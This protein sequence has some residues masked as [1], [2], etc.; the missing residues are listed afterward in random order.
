MLISFPKSNV[1][2]ALI[3]LSIAMNAYSQRLGLPGI[4]NFSRNQ[5]NAGTQNWAISQAENGLLYFANNKGLLEFNGAEWLKYSDIGLVYRSV[6]N[7]GNRI[8]VGGFNFFGYYESNQAG[9]LKYHSLTEML[10]AGERDFD[11]IWKIHKTS[12]G[13]VFQSFRGV[14]IYSENKI[15]IV[16]PRSQFHFSYYV[17]GI[18]WIFDQEAGLM[19][20]REGKVR[21]IP[22]GDR[23]SHIEIWTILPYNDDK[24]LVGT[25]KNGLY[26]Y[27]GQTVAKWETPVSGYLERYQLFAGVK[28]DNNHF[29][30]G[31]VQNGLY[32]TDQNGNIEFNL[33]KERGLQNNTILSVS[34]DQ[35]GNV[36]LG[37]DNGISRID[38]NSPITYIHDYFNIGS[39]Y[40]SAF[41]NEKLY[42]GTN[43]GLFYISVADLHNPQ[44]QKSDFHLVEGTEGQ[45]WTLKVVENTLMCGHNFGIF[46]IID[47]HAILIS[48][49]PGGWNFVKAAD[50]SGLYLSGHYSGISVLQKDR[51]KWKYMYELGGFDQSAHYIE[52]DNEGIVWV[53]HDFKGIYKL[54]TDERIQKVL[55]T[56]FYDEKN[57]LPQK[58]DNRVF[59][60]D[61]KI[62]IGTRSGIYTYEP[63]TDSFIRSDYLSEFIDRSSAVE[64][65]YDDNDQNVWCYVNGQ[66]EILTSYRS[67]N[68]K[69]ISIPFIPLVNQ[70]ITNYGQVNVFSGGDAVIGIEGGFAH[71]SHLKQFNTKIKP[72]I[73]ISSIHSGDT[74]EG[75]F[76]FNSTEGK[77]KII[78]RFSYKG[79][80]VVINFAASQLT[81]AEPAIRY[82]LKGFDQDWSDWQRSF[83]KEY[84]NLPI[85]TYTFCLMT[86]TSE[87]LGSPVFEYKFEIRPPWYRTIYA[88]VLYLLIFAVLVY[89]AY[90]FSQKRMAESRQRTKEK[91]RERYLQREQQLKEEALLAEKG[92]IR[93]RNEHL[94]LE[95]VHKEKELANSTF[96]L[97]QK[98]EIL[99]KIKNDMLK[100]KSVVHDNAVRDELTTAVK[101]IG[102]EID[103]EKQWQLFNT[104]VEQVHEDLFRKL[105]EKFPAL[106]PRELSLCAYLRMN[107]SSKEIATLMNI[108]TRGVEI[109]RYRIRKKMGLLRDDNLTDFMLQL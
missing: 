78:P 92:M 62:I 58:Y 77:Q 35:S 100:I 79:N 41:F 28:I 26:L 70:I 60:I 50:S 53:S 66:P 45:V 32:I 91:E 22:G 99:G 61:N 11:E 73:Y 43:Q 57:G 87:G 2:S 12:F 96:M 68:A 20:L 74:S 40:T 36:W 82:K 5:Y 1:F 80:K 23:F 8:Y 42:L 97:I 15:Q 34:C 14:F 18:L 72:V 30:F 102:K 108:S 89:L 56:G 69:L 93:L 16:K 104:H 71:Y 94:K 63:K 83:K 27:D 44:K 33:N 7:D 52:V 10:P 6:C 55:T 86:M 85:G 76:R 48:A 31:T 21:T 46:Q 109:S 88:L 81:S 3:L 17:N 51:D 98:N 64:F 54:K 90:L 13:V 84:T 101:R 95:M 29:A 59:S 75:I 37:L 65:L 4:T 67:R 38:Y 25:A 24:I 106:T 49:K 47:N 105:K 39:G 107:I 9:M 103:N 19:Q